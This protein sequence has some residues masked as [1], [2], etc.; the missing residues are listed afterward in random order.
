MYE[1][2]YVEIEVKNG[3]AASKTDESY[4]DIIDRA[5]A[6]GWRYVGNIPTTQKGY[7]YIKSFDLIF[8]REKK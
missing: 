6:E 4:R 8:E 7:G 1:Y 5:A 3:F 2:M